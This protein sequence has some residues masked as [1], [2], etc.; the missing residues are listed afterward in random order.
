[1]KKTWKKILAAFCA[2]ALFF[3]GIGIDVLFGKNGAS[4]VQAADKYEKVTL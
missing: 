1:M 4:E 3:N 2:L